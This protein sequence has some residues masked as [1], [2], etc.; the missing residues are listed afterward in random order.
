M[1]LTIFFAIFVAVILVVAR[2]GDW[3]DNKTGF[4]LGAIATGGLMILF[5][6]AAKEAAKLQ[7]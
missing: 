5:F 1:G 7:G 3:I 2:I 6:H 4:V